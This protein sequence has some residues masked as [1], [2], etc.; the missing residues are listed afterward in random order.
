M[1]KHAILFL[2]LRESTAGE[3]PWRSCNVCV[4]CRGMTPRS[5]LRRN[6]LWAAGG[7]FVTVHLAT[8]AVQRAAKS[9]ARSEAARHQEPPHWRFWHF[10]FFLFF[11]HSSKGRT[12]AGV[13]FTRRRNPTQTLNIRLW[14]T[15]LMWKSSSV[16]QFLFN[17]R[18]L[19]EVWFIVNNNKIIK[20]E[21]NWVIMKKNAHR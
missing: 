11:S 9:A 15:K 3:G 21:A 14:I 13:G 20:Y 5:W 4:S 7:A 8:W 19:S 12:E 17:S 2:R 6:W 18:L 16:Q 1:S 10:F